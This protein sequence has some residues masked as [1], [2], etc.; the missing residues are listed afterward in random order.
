MPI[1]AEIYN[2]M[3]SSPS[4]MQKERGKISRTITSWN[5][6]LGLKYQVFFQVFRYEK[7]ILP[8]I[9]GKDGQT[10]IN[11]LLCKKSDIAIAF[12]G[13]KLGTPTKH[14]PSGTV[15]EIAIHLEQEKPVY[16]FFAKNQ[17]VDITDEY[18]R[19]LNYQQEMKA[20][21]IYGEFSSLKELS[22][23]VEKILESIATEV[24]Y[25]ELCSS[26]FYSKNSSLIDAMWAEI[27][28]R[29][30]FLQHQIDRLAEANLQN[31]LLVAETRNKIRTVSEV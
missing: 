24:R 19:L 7:D 20:K 26:D 14:Y 16:L 2:V 11:D 21:G 10:V 1:R 6:K 4:D 3:L 30:A 28:A 27:D 17:D 13:K 29:E 9:T 22:D 25:K 8:R 31:S 5:Q 18:Q 12:F 23:K 15:E